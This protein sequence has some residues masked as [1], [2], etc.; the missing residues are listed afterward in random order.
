VFKIIFCLFLGDFYPTIFYYFFDYGKLMTNP[1]FNLSY[2]L[3]GMFFGSINFTIQKGIVVSNINESNEIK[4]KPYL[5]IPCKIVN[6]YKSCSYFLISFY[7]FFQ[8]IIAIFISCS[9]YIFIDEEPDKMI[10]NS[11][12]NKF[13]I[14]DNEIYVII[15]HSIALIF[16]IK[17][18]NLINDFLS[19]NFWLML[20]KFY[21]TY[22]LIINVIILYV[23]YMS[24]ARILFSDINIILYSLVCGTFL[25]IFSIYIY[26][27]IELPF[28][29]MLKILIQRWQ[30]K[31]EI[32]EKKDDDE[33][34]DSDSDV[35]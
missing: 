34:D 9:I 5:I 29:K 8:I 23:I 32:I 27:F 16:Y 19:N 2:F 30:Y 18:L 31:E 35:D 10:N 24:D 20:N 11:F 4:N 6:Y 14:F 28:K 22:I 15:I 1:I 13:L 21:F 12:L 17:G 26:A 7:V 3:I 25:F 33:D